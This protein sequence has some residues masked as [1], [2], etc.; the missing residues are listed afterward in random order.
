MAFINS[1]LSLFTQ[2]RLTQIEYFKNNP[3]KVQ[4]NTLQELLAK[5]ANTEYGRKYHFDTILTAEQYRE[6]LPVIH[7]EE[8]SNDIHRMMEGENNILWPEEVKWFA[9]SSGTTNAK[10][11]FIPVSPT[12]LEES[13][14]R[15]GKDVIAIFNKLNPEAQVF[16]GKTL[17]LGGSSEV[18]RSN[19]NCQFGDLSAILISN[20]PFWANMMKTPDSSIMLMSNWEEKIEKICETTVKEDV[21]CLAGVP[22]WFLTVINKILEKTGKENLHEV[23]PNLELFIH[24]GISFTPY[25]EQYKRLLPHPKMKYMETY[26]ASEGFFGLQ[27]D[28]ADPSMLLMLDYGI[29]YEFMPMSEMGKQYPRTLLLEEVEPGVNYAM[30]ITTSGGLWRYMIGDTISFTSTKPYKFRITGR[31][32][33][34]INAF[35]EELIIDNATEALKRACEQTGANVFEFTAAPVFMDEGRKGAHE[36]L[37]EFDTPPDNPENFAEILDRELQKLNSDYEAKRLLSLERLKLHVARPG[38]FNDWLKEKGKLGGQ[39]KVPR[40]WNDRTHIDELLK[41]R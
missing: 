18:S 13:H 24:G 35:G 4:R 5:A 23:W 21:R 3:V 25:R 34:F 31:T 19:N 12:I 16:S 37:I 33:L 2:K 9:K 39:H 36:W 30:I 40:L 15:G 28:P 41:M 14:F 26:N 11:K 32:K 10:S 7:Y 27:D 29:Y 8:I 20:T 1:I 17:A 22:S 38:L 6:R